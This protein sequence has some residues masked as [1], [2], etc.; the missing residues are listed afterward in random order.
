MY[1]TFIRSLIRQIWKRC[2]GGIPSV[3]IDTYKQF[4]EGD[5]QPPIDSLEDALLAIIHGFDQIFII[6]DALDECH[7]RDQFLKWLRDTA[8]RREGKL[9]IAVTSR[10]ERDIVD[11]IGCLDRREVCVDADA[12][13]IDIQTYLDHQLKCDSKLN[14]WSEND[15]ASV[16]DKLTKGS[17]GMYVLP[18]SLK[19]SGIHAETLTGFDGL[20]YN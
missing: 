13:N 12:G 18:L 11:I 17:D 15:R 3:L 6:I 10:L 16:K 7:I 4:D 14:R 9:H 1:E 20:N 5:R 2:D 19:L 8:K